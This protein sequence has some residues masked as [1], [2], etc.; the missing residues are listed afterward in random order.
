[1]PVISDVDLYF[2]GHDSQE[3]TKYMPRTLYSRFQSSFSLDLHVL[4]GQQMTS[5]QRNGVS[6]G[7]S[8]LVPLSS[9]L[10]SV[11]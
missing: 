6:S 5:S 8:S 3:E 7:E 4:L 10:L 2:L 11:K 1:M 9:S